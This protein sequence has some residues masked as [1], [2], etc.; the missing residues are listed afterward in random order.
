MTAP[1]SR[2]SDKL[3]DRARDGDGRALGQLL[4]TYRNY[5]RLLAR[6]HIN[7]RLQSKVDPSDLVQEAFIE[8]HRSFGQFRGSSEAE[9]LGWLRRILVSR[10]AAASRRFLHAQARDVRLERH[11]EEE[12]DRSTQVAGA[13]VK[14][15]STPSEKTVRHEQAVLVSN[16]LER[17]AADE[18]DVIVLHEFQGLSF[19]EV[20]WRIGQSLAVTQGL[21]IRGLANLKRQLE[22]EAHGAA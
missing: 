17:L 9:L 3:L 4:D 21:W 14:E 10:L 8:V 15:Q 20:A 19:P 5:L 11:L 22:G 1:A 2:D 16:A 6:L 7:D 12:L 13:L 18:R